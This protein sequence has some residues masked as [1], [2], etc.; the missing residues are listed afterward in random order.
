[1][2]ESPF[3]WMNNDEHYRPKAQYNRG[4]IAEEITYEIVKKI[5]GDRKTLKNL[6]IK[7]SKSTMVTDVDI[8]AIHNSKCIIFQVKSKKLTAL[9]KNGNLESIQSDFKKAVKDAYEQGLNASECIKSPNNFLFVLKSDSNFQF[10]FKIEQ[11]FVVTI[12][13]DDYPAI[14]NQT[15][16]L[17]GK[18]YEEFPVAL[19]IFDLEIVA[20]YLNTPEKFI[21]Y[22]ERRI[23]Y[24][25]Y[26][27]ADNELGFLG[28]HLQK[29]LQKF[30]DSDMIALDESWA[31]FFDGD[32]YCEI[33]GVRKIQE[34]LRKK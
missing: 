15:H 19:N 3:Y 10:N 4:K 5:F 2:Y 33:S 14:T 32:Y 28:F 25:K 27:K 34:N 23:K 20:S 31:Q 12:V 9:S 24:S 17:L 7:K 22:I 18:E 11:S 26:F 29:G 6:I 1:M 8:L 13:L 16:I 30:P 21:D